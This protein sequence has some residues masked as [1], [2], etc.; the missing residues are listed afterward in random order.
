M[1][2]NSSEKSVHENTL[3]QA[4]LW[5]AHWAVRLLFLFL[6]LL[7]L[8]WGAYLVFMH[9]EWG[10][11]NAISHTRAILAHDLDVVSRFGANSGSARIAVATANLIYWLVW[12]VTRIHDAMTAFSDPAP[13]GMLDTFLRNALIVP[14]QSE[15]YVLMDAT[16]IFGIRLAIFITA[17]PVF[18]LAYVVGTVDGLVQRYIRRSGAGRESSSLYHRAKFFQMGGAAF[19]GLIYICLPVAIDPRW[20]MLPSASLLALLARVQWTYFKKYL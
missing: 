20:I 1:D 2:T 3:S 6:T 5:P 11:D 13:R 8:A 19:L 9:F 15:I 14:F 7:L 17:L 12:E 16:K 10:A 4:F 18:L